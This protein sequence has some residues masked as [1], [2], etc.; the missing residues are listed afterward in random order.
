MA[1]IDQLN[2]VL[3]QARPRAS[4]RRDHIR[5]D[6]STVSSLYH[7]KQVEAA[8][9]LGISLTSLKS[10]C[11]RLGIER[12]PYRREMNKRLVANDSM[13][14]QDGARGT[15]VEMAEASQAEPEPEPEPEP[16]QKVEEL[17]TNRMEGDWL[18]WYM[19]FPIEDALNLE[20]CDLTNVLNV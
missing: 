5:L 11:R 19:S 2:S 7:L 13:L 16:G 17:G 15:E 8:K 10:G 1:N 4:H 9:L 14:L 12:W 6:L 20:E 18:N 3:I